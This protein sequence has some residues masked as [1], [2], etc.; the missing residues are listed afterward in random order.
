MMIHAS[1]IN[2]FYDHQVV[3][4]CLHSDKDKHSILNKTLRIFSVL[5]RFSP[6]KTEYLLHNKSE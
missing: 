1:I 2:E 5:T 6:M 3:S 4:R